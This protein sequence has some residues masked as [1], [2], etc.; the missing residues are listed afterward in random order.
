MPAQ[1]KTTE[2]PHEIAIIIARI[3]L[4]TDAKPLI[5]QTHGMRSGLSLETTLIP[6]GNGIPIRKLN[7]ARTQIDR[8]MRWIKDLPKNSRKK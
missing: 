2:Y 1:T 4:T 3:E 7:G 5:D 6:E 8:S